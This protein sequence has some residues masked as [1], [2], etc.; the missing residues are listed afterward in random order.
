MHSYDL[1]TCISLIFRIFQMH[2]R[3]C[4]LTRGIYSS[5]ISNEC[6][7]YVEE[8]LIL[9]TNQ[10]MRLQIDATCSHLESTHAKHFLSIVSQSRCSVSRALFSSCIHFLLGM[11]RSQAVLEF[12]RVSCTV[13]IFVRVKH[14]L[15]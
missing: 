11:K 14:A 7:S 9:H 13:V 6:E 15:L 1:R 12:K 4:Y 8:F 5:F 3:C 2:K 10:K